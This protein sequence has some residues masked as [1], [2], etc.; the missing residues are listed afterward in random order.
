MNLYI[1]SKTVRPYAL[2]PYSGYSSG[3]LRN[4]MRGWLAYLDGEEWRGQ[5]IVTVTPDPGE[6]MEA[7]MDDVI[8]NVSVLRY[9]D[10]RSILI[11]AK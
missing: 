7:D 2:R 10:I 9:E 6:A 11:M 5:S 4:I 1:E 3:E 8:G